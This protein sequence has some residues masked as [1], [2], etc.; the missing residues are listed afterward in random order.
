MKESDHLKT[1]WSSRRLL[2]WRSAMKF[3]P[4]GFTPGRSSSRGKKKRHALK[5]QLVVE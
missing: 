1:A 3:T 4:T 2:T 5:T